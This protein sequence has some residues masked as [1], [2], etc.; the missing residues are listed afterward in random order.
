MDCCS[1]MLCTYNRI[2]DNG[3]TDGSKE[4]LQDLMGKIPQQSSC[5]GY[6]LHLNETNLGIAKGRNLGLHLAN[7]HED[8]WLATMDND[9]EVPIGWLSECIGIMKA[10]SNFVVGVNMESR[11]YPSK[12][13]NNKTFQVK[14]MGN[15]GTACMVFPRVLHEKIGYF[16]EDYEMYAHEDADF[17]FRAR[18][19]KFNLGYIQQPGNHFGIG[20]L[21]Q[22]DYRVFKDAHVK[23]NLPKYMLNCHNYRTG[24]KPLFIP[25]NPIGAE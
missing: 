22:G 24:Q 11:P 20:E 18:M 12:T 6:E 25:Y 15:L 14:Q 1:I 5:L 9:I 23:T 17:G 21:D 13:L 2:V 16:N 7:K 4:W 10:N 19:A 8:R 3:S